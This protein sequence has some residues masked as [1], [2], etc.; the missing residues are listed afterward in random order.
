MERFF[1]V[2]RRYTTESVKEA[3][4]DR[5]LSEDSRFLT[6]LIDGGFHCICEEKRAVTDTLDPVD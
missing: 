2:R 5:S 4:E 6:H 1:R 3:L